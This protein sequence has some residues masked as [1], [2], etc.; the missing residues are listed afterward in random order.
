MSQQ[1]NNNQVN[2]TKTLEILENY[3]KN[4]LFHIMV[5]EM[6]VIFPTIGHMV[7]VT[8]RIIQILRV[9]IRKM[10]IL[11][12]SHGETR[13]VAVIMIIVSKSDDVCLSLRCLLLIANELK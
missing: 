8:I 3:G 6:V 7:R 10:V 5:H 9:K 4:R 12:K 1:N 11:M 13:L 2:F